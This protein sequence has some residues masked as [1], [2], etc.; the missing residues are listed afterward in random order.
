MSHDELSV[1]RKQLATENWQT[2]MSDIKSN[3]VDLKDLLVI[4]SYDSDR[5]EE[6]GE[7]AQSVIPK[8]RAAMK[9]KGDEPLVKGKI[10][11]FI[12]ERRYDFTEFGV[13][14]DRRELPRQVKSRWGY[15][16]CLLYTSPSPRD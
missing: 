1:Q 9:V 4:S 15:N 13:M 2:A 5:I 16:V 12:F 3:T 6:I 14:I 8:I 10:S 11:L 7:V